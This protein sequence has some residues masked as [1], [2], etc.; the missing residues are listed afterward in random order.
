MSDGVREASNRAGDTSVDRSRGGIDVFDSLLVRQPVRPGETGAVR[1][2]L[3]EWAGDHRGGDVRTL[4]PA[5]G[6]NLVTLFFDQGGFEAG[7][8]GPGD[9]TSGP[10]GDALVWYVEMAD[11][12]A[13]PWTDPGAAVR[14]S[15]LFGAGLGDLLDGSGTV[16]ADGRDGCRLVTHATN[17]NRQARYEAHAGRPLLAPVAGEELPVPVVLTSLRLKPGLRTCLVARGVDVVNW[18]KGFGPV[19]R[20][21]RDQTDTLEEEAMYTESLLFDPTGPAPV[22]RYYMETEDMDRLYDAYEASDDWEVRVSDWLFR[23]LFEDPREFLTP[24]LETDCEVLVHAVDPD[25]P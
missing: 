14:E 5:A 3:A 22:V 15:P 6:V 18:L 10:G 25:R 2:L 1:D 16:Y 20:W 21:A 24:P 13:E 9:D 7:S 23:R 4:L 19:R 8:G 12:G 17:P 11:D